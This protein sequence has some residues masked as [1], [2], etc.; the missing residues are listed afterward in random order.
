MS[1][2]WGYLSY[3]NTIPAELPALMEAP[4]RAKC[5]IDR[6]EAQQNAFL[7]MGCGIQ[8]ITPE[9]QHEVLPVFDA[10][11]GIFFTADCILDNRE[12]LISLLSAAGTVSDDTPAA[13]TGPAFS[14]GPHTA[15]AGPT[16]TDGTLMYLAY[17]T[18]GMDC[19]KRFRGLFS[20]A[21]YDA[22]AQTLFLATD[23]T[24]SRCLYYYKIED[25]VCFSTLLE[26]IR[27]V[28][29]ELSYNELYLK[30]YLTAPGL[31]PNIVPTETPYAGVYK[32]N[33]GCYMAITKDSV[34]EHVYYSPFSATTGRTHT[35]QTTQKS[36]H[37]TQ[38]ST[39]KP[40]TIRS[41][42]A[43]GNAFRTLY[44]DCVKDALRTDGEV[45]I[46]MSSGLDSASVGALAAT[47]LR[48]E[49][50][51]LFS[52]TYVPCM[53]PAPDKN[54]DNVHD[55]TADVL[56]IAELH[57]N[58]K[59]RFLNNE[60]KNC[61][62]FLPQG[63]DLLEIPYKAI[64]NL[65]NL[66]EVYQAAR[67]EGCRVVLTGQLG[68]A[69]VSHGYI[70]DVLF[71]DYRRGHFLR[72]LSYLNNHSRRVKRSRK[73][74]L[75]ACIR[76]FRHAKKV[77]ATDGVRELTPD[78]PFLAGDILKEYP[79]TE[80][81]AEGELPFIE[82]V[83]MDR[84]LYP[85]FLYNKA[86]LTYLGE[87]D[88]KLGLAAGVVLRDPTRD[89]RMLEFCAALPY[90]IF[91]YKGTPR[92]LIRGNFADLLPACVL[93]NFMRYGVQNSDWLLRIR[94]DWTSVYPEL[95]SFFDCSAGQDVPYLSM[96]G[97]MIDRKKA[98]DYL[99]SLSESGPDDG[100][101]FECLVF[102]ALFLRFTR[103]KNHFLQK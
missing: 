97:P 95:T 101:R 21:V 47:L 102:A 37:K 22:K 33:P 49:D 96:A 44:T 87:L 30:D 18:W 39:V 15:S 88:T 5:S 61:L 46:S 69:T 40:C 92:W 79:F 85:K 55:E 73:K 81:Y 93:D 34:T 66:S 36:I 70:D 90:H 58:M 42:K 62:E 35:A 71:D 14:D 51:S 50:K 41:A 1:A 78:N 8:Y 91:A 20:M 4:Y 10:E 68:N 74:E 100:F 25:S 84:T 60:G 32:I 27:K 83:P 77:Y 54:K 64:I 13:T 89:P 11:N 38:K 43:Y 23:Q 2:I 52:Y 3:T 16:A 12:E 59:T 67:K 17:K 48:E 56:K 19:L 103:P 80:R 28:H 99:H 63:L 75:S 9:A 29:P 31:M 45:G 7:T 82:S 76:Y 98:E 72:F 65:P 24:A 53:T 26:P 6:Y 57:P 86:T 94:R